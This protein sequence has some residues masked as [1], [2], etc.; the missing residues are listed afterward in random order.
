MQKNILLSLF[1][2][3]A[4]TTLFAQED[5]ALFND[6]TYYS[7]A[8]NALYKTFCRTA[9]EQL[10]NRK[11]QIE[12]LQTKA[13]W[14]NRQTLVKE[15]LLNLLGP[16]PPKTPLNAKITGVIQKEDFSVE[17]LLFESMPGYYVTAA[18]FIPQNIKTKAPAIIY[19]S[20]HSANGFRSEVYQHVIINLVKK[21]FIV[22]AFDPVGQ[23][24]RL[25]Y[26]DTATGKS[27]FSPTREHSYP[28]AQCYVAGYSPTKYFVW[29]AMRAVDY[30]LTRAEVDPQRIGMTGR[31]GGGTQTA[32][33][34]A[35]DDR[36]L[37]A[38]PECFITNMEYVLKTIGPQD[39]E[40]NLYHMIAE[41]LDHAD[42]LEVRAPKP[43]LMITTTRDMFS[44][45]GARET[46]AEVR[47]AYE[48]FG[49]GGEV[50]MVED[51]APHASTQK[52]REAM[53]AFFQAALK[54]PGSAEDL[55]VEVF[56]EEDLWVTKTGQLATSLKS[57]SL[58]TL[59]KKQVEEQLTTLVTKR[60]EKDHL[61][62][63]LGRAK[64]VAGFTYPKAYGTAIF[65]GRYVKETYLLE[66]YLVPG[67]GDYMLP[68]ALF[69]PKSQ[70]KKE[71]VLLLDDQGME[72]AAHADSLVY[73]ML[74]E[75]YAVLVADLPGIGSLGPGYLK[76]DAYIDRT[77]LNQWFAG[78]LV[79]Q[80]VLGLRVAD[81]VRLLAVIKSDFKTYQ[82]ISCIAKG[83]L[84]S[85]GLHAAAFGGDIAKLCLLKPFLSY[86]DLALSTTYPVSWM[87]SIVAGGLGVYDL[88]DLMAAFSPRKLLMIDPQSAN[89]ASAEKSQVTS[90]IQ[91][92]KYIYTAHNKDSNFRIVLDSNRPFSTQQLLNWLKE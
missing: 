21:G 42:L 6:W 27:R 35:I 3:L 72:R 33:A 20:G 37:A 2:L 8:E 57:E 79:G 14:Q 29:D 41:G 76:G 49:L 13:D 91:Y 51:D 71:L 87:Y 89:G 90:K 23:G 9:F 82:T 36:I 12:Q 53:Y 80:S 88:P 78:I 38:A 92:P 25:Q 60:K 31:S 62:H 44:I 63:V 65:S 67:S 86:G 83:A 24:E 18:L 56:N 46:Y 59:N 54:H 10:E 15:K 61:E 16:L 50:K 5:L 81:L 69:I 68:M 34:A 74:A 64:H 19:A 73:S 11:T 77:S 70:A 84:A 75:G 45:Q 52:N 55:T 17:K 43:T 47:K 39:A 4:S 28:G 7:D 32:Y 58:F 22:L 26:F 30:L 85:E 40:Q 48:A 66:K 1:L